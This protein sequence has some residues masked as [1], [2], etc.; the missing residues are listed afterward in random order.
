MPEL[1]VG[2][3]S[4][5]VP[6]S[7]QVSMQ[8][9]MH[10]APAGVSRCSSSRRASFGRNAVQLKREVCMLK[11]RSNRGRVHLVVKA[12]GTKEYR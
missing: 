6:V 7:M 10:V 3:M 1:G 12:E 5:A 2:A 8:V 9:S 4:F 11:A